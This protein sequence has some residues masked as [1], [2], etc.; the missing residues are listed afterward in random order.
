MLSLALVGFSGCPS[1]GSDK[2]KI[3]PDGVSGD[4]VTGDIS[5]E[6]V[7][8]NSC[9]DDSD[10]LAGKC[11]PFSHTCVECL[12]DDDCGDMEK[13]EKWECVPIIAC[14]ADGDCPEGLLCDVD[15][16]VCV[17]C[18]SDDD[19]PDGGECVDNACV[20]P[21]GDGCPDGFVCDELADICV[22]C[23]GDADC[24]PEEWCL[25]TDY[26]CLEDQCE[27]GAKGC[28]GNA[29]ATCAENGSGWADLVPCGDGL[30][31]TDGECVEDLLCEPGLKSCKD[32]AT[33]LV[34]NDAGTELLE[35]A[36]PEDTSCF[37]GECSKECVPDCEGKECGASGCPDFSCGECQDEA[38]CGEDFI[39]HKGLCPPGEAKCIDG[40]ISKCLDEDLGWSEP[41]PCPPGT[42]CIDAKCQE[43]G[44]ECDPGA[45]ACKENVV[46]MCQEDGQGWE[47]TEKCPDG[48]VCEAGECIPKPFE[49]FPWETACEGDTVIGCNE[50]G[51]GWYVLYECPWPL[52]CSGGECV[53]EPFQC[54]PGEGACEGDLVLFCGD[55]GTWHEEYFCP[56]GTTCEQG[57][58]IPGQGSCA[59][60]LECAMEQVCFEPEPVCFQE[61][62]LL[63]E[64]PDLA[65]ELYFCV[66]ETCGM[67][68]PD[69]ECFEFAMYE[70]C[71]ELFW[72]CTGGCLP[73]CDGKDCGP[74]GC[75]GNCGTCPFGSTCN[76]ANI[77][78]IVCVPDCTGVECGSDGCGGSCGICGPGEAC[79][80][81]ECIAS[82]SCKELTECMFGCPPNDEDCNGECWADTSSDA[83]QQWMDVMACI[84]DVCGENGPPPCFGEA[85]QGE[86][87]EAWN[88]CQ[89][90]TPECVGKQC[91]DDGCGGDCGDCPPG[92]ACD[93]FG[94][95]LCQPQCGGKQCGPD[96]CGG[97]CG[98]C[99]FGDVCNYM[100]QCVCMP[101]CQ[102]KECGYDGC[103]GECGECPE[104]LFCTPNG[105]CKQGQQNCGDGFCKPNIGENCETCPEDCGDCWEG[106]CCQP[107]DFPGC[108]DEEIMWCVC[109]FDPFCCE[110]MWD[111]ICVD[112]AKNECGM[113]YCACQPDCQGKQCGPNGCGGQCGQCPPGFQCTD[114]GQCQQP[115]NCGNGWCQ[116]WQGE[117]CETC[118]DDCGIC[119]ECGDGICSQGENCWECPEDC[120]ECPPESCCE[121][122]DT[123]GCDDPEVVECVCSNDAFCCNN[124]WD[125]ICANAAIQQCNAPCCEPSCAS[126]D[127]MIKECGGDGCGGSCGECPDGTYCQ[128]GQCGEN[129]GCTATNSPGCGGC[130]CQAC[131]CQQDPYCCNTAWDG[132]CVNECQEDC[133]GCGVMD[134]CGDGQCD[135]TVGETCQT[136]PVDCGCMDFEICHQG[137][138]CA[139]SCEGKECGGDGCGG[140]CGSCSPAESCQ[141][142][143]CVADPGCEGYT[144]Q[145]CC[146]GNTLMW[147]QDGEVLEQSCA[148]NPQCGWSADQGYYNCGTN[149][150]AEPSG[151]HPI[152]CPGACEPQCMNADGTPKACGDDGCGGSCGSCADNEECVGGACQAKKGKLGDPCQYGV[153]CESGL[154]LLT[155]AGKICTVSCANGE[156][157]AGYECFDYGNGLLACVP[158]GDCIPDCENKECG[159]DS[160]QGSCGS[161][162]DNAQCAN[163]QCVGLNAPTKCPEML[164]C[165][166][167]CGFSMMCIWGCYGDG[168]QASKDLFEAL[169]GCVVSDC[170]WDIINQ[171]CI[172]ESLEGACADAHKACQADG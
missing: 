23:L 137:E 105:K 67:W 47:I 85:I 74:D 108:K 35:E 161:C 141:D 84:Q 126:E 75:G 131:V 147:C 82:L 118:P 134:D 113:N 101:Q 72:E 104:G 31:C 18:L 115:D 62:M 8:P 146:D 98:Q 25:E 111:E 143:I 22:E 121:P 30:L 40:G 53:D 20:L 7:E 139:P 83:K 21:C 127:G 24:L 170:G 171:Q 49:C 81:H 57:D 9:E 63:G 11:N 125:N 120:G 142:G 153:Q 107:H 150:A 10:C 80:N 39:C 69:S 106:D 96:G 77:C 65:F 158:N 89:D 102:N 27:P 145:G 87:A 123:P 42:I 140:D 172:Y 45:L 114:S 34:C 157:P 29:T 6:T 32:D 58:C 88:A 4:I 100:G 5:G 41:E 95:C 154:C 128:D 138:C 91:G 167:D 162:P 144:W 13:C 119:I 94:T 2:P 14:A 12:K 54:E 71:E 151:Q 99:D 86:C 149:G 169:T 56:P 70:K 79:K 152:L 135:A 110:A 17:E 33:V 59:E 68:E 124:H 97:Q 50:E 155:D 36:C 37:N 16:A 48:T 166:L 43:E 66:W 122:H 116:Q 3:Y 52:Y 78:E 73:E 61:C 129:D 51:T 109:E 19:C 55:D 90:C 15:A 165:A 136:C 44:K 164:E 103:D 159:D 93:N 160:C 28:V 26:L 130:S 64:A 92:Y 60:M 117:N 76:S 133:G 168:T 132:I 163:G 38:Y 112:E 156:C 1:S 46:M 148:N